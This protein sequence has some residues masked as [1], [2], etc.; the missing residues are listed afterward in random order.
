MEHRVG[1]KHLSVEV[2]AKIITL[3]KFSNL[4]YA[5]IAKECNC[6]VSDQYV[7]LE[8]AIFLIK[9]KKCFDFLAVCM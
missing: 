4:T 1:N 8:F 6:S 3:K 7:F 9:S 2:R 5:E